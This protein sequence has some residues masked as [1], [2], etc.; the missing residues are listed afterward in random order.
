MKILLLL[1]IPLIMQAQTEVKPSQ[2]NFTPLPSGNQGIFVAGPSGAL[3]INYQLF[4]WQIDIVTSVMPLLPSANTWTGANVFSG[5]SKTAPFRVLAADPTTCDSVT[6]ESWLNSTTGNLKICLAPGNVGTEVNPTF[7]DGETPG[8]TPNGTLVTFTLAN[9][10]GGSG[11]ALHLYRNGLRQKAGVDYTISGSTITFLP[12]SVPQVGDS[13][14][15][16]YRF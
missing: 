7:V 15:A 13:L 14:L 9:P 5:A 2:I 11:S 6:K 4:P 10:P 1:S 16:D 12:V 3:Q 8:G